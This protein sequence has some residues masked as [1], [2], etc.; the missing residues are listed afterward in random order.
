MRVFNLIN[1]TLVSVLSRGKSSFYIL[2]PSSVSRKRELGVDNL[3]K[4]S[5]SS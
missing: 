5:L 3:E 1:Y 2:G 4:S